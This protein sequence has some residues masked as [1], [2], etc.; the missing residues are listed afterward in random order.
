[1][2]GSSH[3]SSP[4]RAFFQKATDPTPFLDLFDH[5]PDVYLFVKDREHRFV[6]VNSSMLILHGV[7]TEADM[8]GRTD[9]DF[10]PPA[11][12][13]QY[14]E[15]D[16]RVMDSGR[17]LVDQAWLVQ[18]SD[19]LPQW[20]L[21]SKLPV[22]DARGI[23]CG[24]AGVLRPFSRGSAAPAHYD[25]LTAACEFVLRHYAEPIAVSDLARRANI[26]VSQLQREFQRLFGMT[27][28]DY[29]LRVR[30]L[31]ARRQLVE[32]DS[33]VGEIA[34]DCGFYDQSHFTRAFRRANG[35]T[36]LAHRRRFQQRSTATSRGPSPA[37][38]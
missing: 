24:L 23:V 13:A 22:R 35:V 4:A 19:G 26:S 28:S 1:M 17:A 27:P 25:R 18:D 32:T 21:S 33:P 8:I 14:V 30:L 31:M 20:Y 38:P 11:H 7:R 12:A 29:L 15:E 6:R 34:L 36:P 5:L 2:R 9:F 37:R 3:S 10:H 16:A